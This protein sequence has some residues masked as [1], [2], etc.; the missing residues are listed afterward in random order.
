[1]KTIE[2]KGARVPALG[3]GTWQL[4]G[5]GCA[6][7]VH[8]A[9]ELGYRHIDTAQMYGN[10]TEVGRAIRD[11]GI[12]RGDIFLT[13]KVAPGSL[14]A[15]AL[16]RSVAESLKR[17]GVEQVDLLLIHWPTGEAPLG[18][19]LGA[20]AALRR[21][22]KTRFIGVSNFT[23][24]LLDETIETH[25]ADILCDQVEYHP[26]LSQRAVLAAVARHGLMLTAYT[27]LARGR[28]QRDETL[29]AIGAKHGKTAAQIALRWLIDQ[30]NVAAIPK[31]GSRAHAAAN[32][33]IFDFALAAEDRAAI[34][35]M[36][37]DLRV[38][39]PGWGP[40]W[41]PP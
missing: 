3:F 13:T 40:H 33:D 24:K 20:L 17:L 10:E 5:R 15:P 31:A 25:G 1:M 37:G 26:F 21:E 39:D 7:A 41:D 12:A 36:R 34:D 23:V 4:S 32:I 11:S 22:G 8:H 27:P 14:A 2:V 19:T 28:A 16:R 18:E 6:Q 38:V 30:P 9:L 35:A 29:A